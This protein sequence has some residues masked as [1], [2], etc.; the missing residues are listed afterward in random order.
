MSRTTRLSWV[1]A[2]IYIALLAIG[3]AG[4]ATWMFRFFSDRGDYGEIFAEA[5]EEGLRHT[6]VVGAPIWLIGAAVVGLL[7]VIF[8]WRRKS[9]ALVAAALAAPATLGVLY[10]ADRLLRAME[11]SFY[12]QSDYV[13]LYQKAAYPL[14]GLTALFSLLLAIDVVVVARRHT[15]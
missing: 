3:S 15:A 13:R 9:W 7:V 10:V 4:A 2:E 8:L 5:R 14:V 12:R 11:G 6:L 1:A